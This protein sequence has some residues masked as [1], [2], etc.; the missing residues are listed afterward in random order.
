LI[1][2]QKDLA[3]TEWLLYP[4]FTS[5]IRGVNKRMFNFSYP[6]DSLDTKELARK[7]MEDL[8]NFLEEVPFYFVRGRKEEISEFI[9]DQL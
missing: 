9:K 4:E 5:R 3:E 2:Y 1:V 7:R 6:L 8:N